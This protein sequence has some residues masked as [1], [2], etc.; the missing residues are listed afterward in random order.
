MK[1]LKLFEDKKTEDEL[2]E[3]IPILYDLFQDLVDNGFEIDI[4]ESSTSKFNFSD[5]PIYKYDLNLNQSLVKGDYIKRDSLD[6]NI[7]MSNDNK[8][9]IRKI[10]N[11]LLFVESYITDELDLVINYIQ[12][13]DYN[14]KTY[15]K[16]I[17][18]LPSNKIIYQYITIVV[19]KKNS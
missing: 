19:M 5:G 6:I 17:K 4:E 12:I 3:S 18:Y 8:F 15:Y 14:K 13:D 2:L 11:N 10:K 9:N 1:Y 16:S 7:Y